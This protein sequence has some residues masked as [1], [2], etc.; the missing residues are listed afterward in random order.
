MT[1]SLFV[2]DN[3]KQL[4]IDGSFRNLLPFFRTSWSVGFLNSTIFNSFHKRVEF[5]TILEGLRNFGAG[6]LNPP[7]PPLLGTPLVVTIS[8][9]SLMPINGQGFQQSTSVLL[10]E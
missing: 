9:F 4:R 3:V 2:I 10:P 6:G 8:M 5:G 1:T 7:Y